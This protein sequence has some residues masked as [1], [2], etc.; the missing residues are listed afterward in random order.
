MP[1]RSLVDELSENNA[2]LGESAGTDTEDLQAA[3]EKYDKTSWKNCKPP[4]AAMP[5]LDKILLLATMPS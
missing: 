2:N 4:L 5:M 3:I 1:R